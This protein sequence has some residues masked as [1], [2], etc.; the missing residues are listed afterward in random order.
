M[1]GGRGARTVAVVRPGRG[2][3]TYAPPRFAFTPHITLSFYR[4]LS[5]DE[6]RALLAL[7]IDEPA[8]VTTIECSLSNDPQPAHLLLALPLLGALPRVPS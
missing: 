2:R 8:E 1:G 5:A 3:L 4:Q 7:R 6:R